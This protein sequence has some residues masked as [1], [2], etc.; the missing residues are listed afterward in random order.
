MKM[1]HIAV[2]VAGVALTTMMAEA[3]GNGT[4][5]GSGNGQQKQKKSCEACSQAGSEAKGQQSSCQ[6]KQQQQKKEQKK[7]CGSCRE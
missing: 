1:K 5:G 2:I 7:S 3:K 6:K 4:C